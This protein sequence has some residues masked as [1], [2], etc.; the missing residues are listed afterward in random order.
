MSYTVR[1]GKDFDW[2]K[3][4]KLPG[5]CDGAENVSGGRPAHGTNGFSARLMWRK[6]GRGEAYLYHKN[7]P[8]RYGDQIDFPEDF[9]FPTETD[10]RVRMRMRVTMNDPGKK[11]G[12]IIVSIRFGEDEDREVVKCGDLEW[13][14]VDVFGID[15]LYFESFH[16]GSDKSWA[17]S[18]PSF[19]EFG[20]FLIRP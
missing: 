1:F 18:N 8:E 17:P 11:N 6:E 5:F 13:G 2:V 10:I 12:S 20:D 15:S 7:Q 16:G 14:S 4:G 9:R 19:A 3:G